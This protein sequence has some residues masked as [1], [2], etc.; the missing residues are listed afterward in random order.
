MWFGS[1][2]GSFPI[3]ATSVAIADMNNDGRNDLLLSNSSAGLDVGVCLRRGDGSFAA[4]LYSP[5]NAYEATNFAL[6]DFNGDGLLDIATS[7]FRGLVVGLE[8]GDGTFRRDLALDTWRGTSTVTAGDVN[9][10]GI[11]DLAVPL[12]GQSSVEVHLGQGGG[13]FE[14]ARTFAVGNYPVDAA[15]ADFDQDGHL[16]LA[17]VNQL[18]GDVSILSGTGT[19]DFLTAKNYPVPTSPVAVTTLD[20]D[21][22]GR[23]DLAVAL[24]QDAPPGNLLLL[25]GRGDGTFDP[26]LAFE[27]A[28][29]PTRLA[30]SDM[31]GDGVDD[32]ICSSSF[33]RASAVGILFGSRQ[34]DYGAVHSFATGDNPLGLAIGD[35]DGDGKLDVVTGDSSGGPPV[36]SDIAVL[37]GGGGGLGGVLSA[38]W[39]WPVGQVPTAIAQ[40]DL[41][42]D[43]HPDLVTANSADGTMSVL[44]AD[45]HGGLLPRRRYDVGGN[46]LSVVLADLDNDGKTDAAI[47][48][49][50]FVS[51]LR[52][53]GDG[54]FQTA[55]ATTISGVLAAIDAGDV[56]GDGRVDLLVGNTTPG[57][58]RLLLGHGDGTFDAPRSVGRSDYSSLS[59]EIAHIDPGGAADLVIAG[60]NGSKNGL[61]VQRG[62]GDGSFPAPETIDIGGVGPTPR[63]RGGPRR[64]PTSI[65]TGASIW[66]SP[67]R[68]ADSSS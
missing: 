65:A 33:T 39:L 53:N 68:G 31:D 19:G 4:P 5:L 25:L 10:D 17:V 28:N 18:S 38:P 45:G 7:G 42:R 35:L 16:D 49:Y 32:L 8:N 63:H 14:P 24:E 59:A 58:T 67:E 51:V 41:D 21:G 26:P 22:D 1:V 34:R 36:P 3:T 60:T 9:A 50:Q 48:G 15:L 54:T 56:N 55:M 57:G 37:L 13:T 6:A 62:N 11:P 30:V 46:P 66:P 20:I 27:S 61:V 43:G 23:V 12:F 47:A 64:V 29:G 40:G 2:R 52:G 44:L